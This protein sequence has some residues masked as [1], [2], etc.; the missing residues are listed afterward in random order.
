M[1][2]FELSSH[3]SLQHITVFVISI[4]DASWWYSIVQ[5]HRVS[6]YQ[7]HILRGS[8]W[9]WY[10]L[11]IHSSTR[12]PHPDR[13]PAVPTPLLP[14]VRGRRMQRRPAVPVLR[15]LRREAEVLQQD[16]ADRQVPL[17]AGVVQSRA[18]LRWS[19]GIGDT[20]TLPSENSCSLFGYLPDR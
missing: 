10:L 6:M 19:P 7:L 16:V 5:Y 3:I 13:S 18:A 8:I 4:H 14:A 20:W 17:D 15:V 11:P 1:K 12:P 2:S 9:C